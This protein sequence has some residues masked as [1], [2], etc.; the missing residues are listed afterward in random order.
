MKLLR[1]ALTLVLA[2]ACGCA[3]SSTVKPQPAPEV[4]LKQMQTEI[5]RTLVA[6]GDYTSLKYDYTK[7]AELVTAGV[8]MNDAAGNLIDSNMRYFDMMGFTSSQ[9]QELS[10]MQLAPDDWYAMK[11]NQAELARQQ[12]FVT[13]DK[14]YTAKDGS[15]M[16]VRITGW[17]LRGTDGAIIG[18]GAL[19]RERTEMQKPLP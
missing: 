9:L 18:T 15:V 1:F 17:V 6:G 5:M 8:A 13:F 4:R 3:A 7:Y 2:A 11:G 16:P 12:D 19:V 10:A 14:D